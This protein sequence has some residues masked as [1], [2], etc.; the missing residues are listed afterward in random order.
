MNIIDLKQL[1]IPALKELA[2]K[3]LNIDETGEYK[4]YEFYSYTSFNFEMPRNLNLPIIS[5][6]VKITNL[7][8]IAKMTIK[9]R[10][11]GVKDLQDNDIYEGENGVLFV[12]ISNS[13][14]GIFA[15]SNRPYFC[16]PFI[17]F[18]S[19]AE[20]SAKFASA[21]EDLMAEMPMNMDE[22]LRL[23][24]TNRVTELQETAYIS[25]RGVKLLNDN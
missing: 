18:E 2:Q 12:F 1:T 13:S 5:C 4:L 23:R 21:S 6:Q 9:C 24:L 17:K 3:I 8:P 19:Q 7:G 15:D 10:N 11:L 25:G 14:P 22:E 16:T 20:M